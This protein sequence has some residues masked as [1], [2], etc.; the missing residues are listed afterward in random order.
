MRT[1]W[2]FVLISHGTF[3][4]SGKSTESRN[5][6]PC[7]SVCQLWL[8][9]I[10]WVHR[11]PLFTELHLEISLLEQS[12]KRPWRSA[13]N[14]RYSEQLIQRQPCS[15]HSPADALQSSCRWVGLLTWHLA[16]GLV[17]ALGKYQVLGKQET[18]I[19]TLSPAEKRVVRHRHKP[20]LVGRQ[21]GEAEVGGP[22]SERGQML[23][24][25]SPVLSGLGPDS[26]S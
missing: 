10:R 16:S 6:F 24:T 21:W 8:R 13:V 20:V 12:R 23:I 9:L 25:P 15:G 1:I 4:H 19:S 2:L 18:Q 3:A 5:K 7:F 26:L 17:G 11:T 22:E 14:A